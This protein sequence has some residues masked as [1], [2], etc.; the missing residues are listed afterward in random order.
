MPDVVFRHNLIV[1]GQPVGTTSVMHFDFRQTWDRGAVLDVLIHDPAQDLHKALEGASGNPTPEITFELQHMTSEAD[2]YQNFGTQHKVHIQKA[3]II[4]TTAGLAIKIR[5]LD[6]ASLLLRQ[7]STAFHQK[8]VKANQ[9]IQNLCNE[10]GVTA[11]IP[12]TGDQAAVHRGRHSHPN[13]IIRYELDRVLSASGKPITLQYDT[14]AEEDKLLGF[15]ELYDAPTELYEDTISGG[16]YSHGVRLDS[17]PGPGATWGTVAHDFDMGID[18]GQAL[19]GHNV[20][21]QQLMSNNSAVFGDVKSKL[22]AN[23]GMGGDILE[24]AHQRMQ[25]ARTFTDDPTTDE[26]F[27]RATLVNRV[28]HNEMSMTNGF[29]LLDADFK[30]FDDPAILNRKHIY[31]GVASGTNEDQGNALIPLECVVMGWQ[32]VLNRTGAYTKLLLRRGK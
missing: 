9:Y 5:A 6:K 2:S 32:H 1:A 14:R 12:D 31:V 4:T 8:A 3:R 23:L 24:N 22:D 27:H 20:T 18:Y 13:H 21:G 19:W 25:I 15:E 11:E 7:E 17:V 26:Y 29:V 10:V 16:T 30:A 28:F